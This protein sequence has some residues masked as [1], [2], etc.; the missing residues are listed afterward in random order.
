MKYTGI[1]LSR[2]QIH[3][4]LSKLKFTFALIKISTG[5]SK[6]SSCYFKL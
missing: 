3:K 6:N 5:E 4:V 2:I 1:H